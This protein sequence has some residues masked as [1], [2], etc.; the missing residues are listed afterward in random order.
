MIATIDRAAAADAGR[1][2]KSAK[3]RFYRDEN[4]RQSDAGTLKAVLQMEN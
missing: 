1:A 2:E 3:R 4:R